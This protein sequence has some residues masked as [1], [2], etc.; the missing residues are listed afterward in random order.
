MIK[1]SAELV[2]SGSERLTSHPPNSLP[3][4]KNTYHLMTP[5]LTLRLLN[6]KNNFYL[7]VFKRHLLTHRHP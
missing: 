1:A 6:S 5:S 4:Y 2:V 7:Q 3:H